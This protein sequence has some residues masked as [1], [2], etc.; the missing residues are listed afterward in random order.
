MEEVTKITRSLRGL[1][2]ELYIRA[3]ADALKRGISIGDWM[4]EAMAEKLIITNGGKKGG[5]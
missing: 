1:E 4:N 3:R 2:R 5:K